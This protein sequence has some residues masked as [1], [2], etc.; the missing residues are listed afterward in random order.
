M[1]LV[2]EGVYYGFDPNVR[3]LGKVKQAV[4]RLMS[5]LKKAAP[6]LKSGVIRLVFLQALVCVQ[7]KGKF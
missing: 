6:V 2:F 5:N 4:E 1:L 7:D 3:M